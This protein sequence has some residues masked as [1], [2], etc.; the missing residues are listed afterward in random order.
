MYQCRIIIAC[1]AFASW[2]TLIAGWAEHTSPPP[3]LMTRLLTNNCFCKLCQ[4]NFT[5]HSSLLIKHLSD[6]DQVIL[7]T[8]SSIWNL[9]LQSSSSS[10]ATPLWLRRSQHQATSKYYKKTGIFIE[11][12]LV[13]F[14]RRNGR[15]F[16]VSSVSTTSTLSTTTLCYFTTSTVTVT[17]CGR[18]RRSIEISGDQGSQASP[19]PVLRL[20]TISD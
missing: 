11:Y 5:S 19:S 4:K 2:E 16:F 8:Q 18:K 3:G 9:L 1:L 17:A 13:L 7:S 6:P 14:S 20:K 15:L 10:F 12:D